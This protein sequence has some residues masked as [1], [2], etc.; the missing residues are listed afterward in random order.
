MRISRHEF[1]QTPGDGKRQGSLAYGSPWG[2][3][4]SDSTEQLNNNE[5][6]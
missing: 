2:F 3:K 1:E 5:Y 6:Q 4:E